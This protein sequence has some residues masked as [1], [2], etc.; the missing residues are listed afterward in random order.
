M[1]EARSVAGGGGAPPIAAGSERPAGGAGSQADTMGLG[2]SSS[3]ARSAAE[4]DERLPAVHTIADVERYAGKRVRVLGRYEVTP[5][6]GSKRLQPACIVLAD[7]T[8]L[9]RSYRP[10]LEELHFDGQRV[11][12]VGKALLDAGEGASVQQVMAPHVAIESLRL[13][14]IES[15]YA[16]GA[17]AVRTPPT[18]A[19][20]RD[21]ASHVDRWVQ[22]FGVLEQINDHPNDP[23]WVDMRVRLPDGS[24]IIA[25]TIARSRV[26]TLA[27]KEISLLALVAREQ[28]PSGPPRVH[29]AHVVCAGR[30]ERCGMGP[31]LAPAR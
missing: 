20:A 14:P 2:T 12:A 1:G 6:A 30:V 25:E 23:F 31:P 9:V 19:S 22:L 29:P 21:A 16:P 26:E 24:L 7:G 5:V 13:D 18:L 8:R 27:G 4:G 3:S 10:V 28:P 11:I 15:P 17:T